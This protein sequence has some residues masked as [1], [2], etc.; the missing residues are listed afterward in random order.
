[1]LRQ[2]IF[3]FG[4]AAAWAVGKSCVVT[5]KRKEWYFLLKLGR[6]N[7]YYVDM[8]SVIFS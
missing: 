4:V 1:M 7:V 6:T 2:Y 5:R 3:L 8:L